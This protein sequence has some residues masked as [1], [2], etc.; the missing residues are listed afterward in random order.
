MI[1]LPKGLTTI[2][3]LGIAI[4]SEIEA[5]R[6]YQKIRRV[7]QSPSLKDKLGFLIGEEEKHQ[8]ILTDYYHKKFPGISVSTP[9]VSAV[10]KPV[11][12]QKGKITVSVLLKAAMKAEVAASKFYLTLGNRINDIQGSLLLKYLSKVENSHYHLLK[13]ELE[14]IEQGSR[15]KGMKTVYQMD[16]AVHIGP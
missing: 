2:A 7:V 10:P 5:A 11:I 3:V 9:F 8:L 14:L 6:Y 12:P 4:Q 1:K 13:N 15:I 16:R